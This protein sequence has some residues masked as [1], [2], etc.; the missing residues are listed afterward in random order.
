MPVFHLSD[1]FAWP[2]ILGVAIIGG[3]LYAL[4]GVVG[5]VAAV[6]LLILR[7]VIAPIYVVVMAHILLLALVAGWPPLFVFVG[8]EFGALGLLAR[9]FIHDPRPLRS[10]G[11]LVGAYVVLVGGI[12]V[13]VWVGMAGW[14][15]T[16]V[17]VGS[18]AVTV[19]SIHRLGVIRLPDR[20]DSA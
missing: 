17:L 8:F 4:A 11:A 9:P 18:V 7:V 1:R 6:G 13:L 20:V 10:I 12:V 2:D 14:I 19:F 16:G 3:A 5:G 15:T